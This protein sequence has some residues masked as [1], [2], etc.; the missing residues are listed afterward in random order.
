MHAKSPFAKTLLPILAVTLAVAACATGGT[1]AGEQAPANAIWTETAEI[2]ADE[3]FIT[4]DR[5]LEIVPLQIAVDSATFEVTS[6]ALTRDVR[7]QSTGPL[8]SETIPPYHLQLISTS[9][10]PSATIRVSK[11]REE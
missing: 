6:E 11:I 1:R 3:V 8:S 7:L 4:R 9:A 2:R 10:E 5:A